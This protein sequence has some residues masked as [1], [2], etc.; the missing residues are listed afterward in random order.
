[1]SKAGIGLKIGALCMVAFFFFNCAT[2]SSIFTQT[3]NE[4]VNQFYEYEKK[5]V[6]PTEP[7]KIYLV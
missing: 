5:N 6:L 3:G 1:M 7:E 2:T 4:I